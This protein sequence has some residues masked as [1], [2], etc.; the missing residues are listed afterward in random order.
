[1]TVLLVSK[2][3]EG[4]YDIGEGAKIHMA[5]AD[6]RG[7]LEQAGSVRSPVLQ[8]DVTITS[9]QLLAL[10]ATPQT[11]VA[12]P[13]AGLA[14]VPAGPVAAVAFLDYNSAAYGGI[15]AGE[16]LAF[17]YTDDAGTELFQIETTGFLDQTS[18]QVRFAADPTLVT[19]EANVP[20]VLHMLVGEVTT[21][22]SPLFVRFYYRL[23]PTTLS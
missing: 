10:N 3:S 1:M 16:D 18:D 15:A 12:A 11:I 4:G 9:A 23:I 14:I 22:D 2:V 19:P 8:A 6:I 7:D 17:K 5:S 20:V 13:G 21:G